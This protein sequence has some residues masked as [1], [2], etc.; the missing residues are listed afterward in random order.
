MKIMLL[1]AMLAAS[2]TTSLL[3][4]TADG[5]A[6]QASDTIAYTDASQLR[7]VNRAFSDVAN[8]YQRLPEGIK[9]TVRKDV[10]HLAGN[11]AGI[12]VRF[13]TNSHFVATRYS[14]TNNVVMNHMAP[15]GIKGVDLYALT[16]DG[17]WR[18]VMTGRPKGKENE[19]VLIDNMEPQEREYMLYLPLYDGVE[20]L[21]IGVSR[22]ARIDAGEAAVPQAE[23]PV[24]FYGTSI[25]QGGCA[26]RPGMAYTNILSRRLGREVI[27]LGFSGNGKLDL[28]VA[29]QMARLDTSVYVIDCLP[30]CTAELVREQGLTF[31]EILRKAHPDVPIV[32]TEGP[33]FPHQDYNTSLRATLSEKTAAWHD[34]YEA[35]RAKYPDNVY[36]VGREGFAGIDHES[37][38]DGTHLTDLGFQ[39]VADTLEPVL[40]PLVEK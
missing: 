36:Y 24:V 29:Q 7:I 5:A 39:R 35:F 22:D 37:F 16:P 23:R 3:A 27:N 9:P 1:S 34:V 30:N 11:S 21:E 12:A 20:S 28:D 31:L 17:T 10:W 40:R 4:Q 18:Y 32:M 6:Q 33:Y 25:T 19:L 26:S 38:V 15:T 13:R 8:P 2:L 14:L